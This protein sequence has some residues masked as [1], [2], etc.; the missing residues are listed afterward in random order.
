MTEEEL[1]AKKDEIAQLRKDVSDAKRATSSAALDQARDEQAANLDAEAARLRQ[2]LEAAKA[3]LAAQTGGTT[4]DAKAKMDA[5]A[6]LQAAH[7]SANNAPKADEDE[8]PPVSADVVGTQ[9]EPAPTADPSPIAP[10]NDTDA[11]HRDGSQVTTENS[12]E[13]NE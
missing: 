3:G 7:S 8:T 5:A 4:E 9:S 1:Q 12:G 10:E 13:A 2:E 11:I 6:A